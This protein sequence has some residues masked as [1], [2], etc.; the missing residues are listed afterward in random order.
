[1]TGIGFLPVAVPEELLF[2][3]IHFW[4]FSFAS[5]AAISS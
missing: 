3:R 1:V 4:V 2:V 5:A